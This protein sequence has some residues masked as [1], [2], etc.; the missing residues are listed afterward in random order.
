MATEKEGCETTEAQWAKDLVRR[1]EEDP[2]PYCEGKG[3][4]VILDFAGTI[5]TYNPCPVCDGTG[6]RAD[7]PR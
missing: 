6:I 3:V 2:C 1:R 5:P 4:V 7:R